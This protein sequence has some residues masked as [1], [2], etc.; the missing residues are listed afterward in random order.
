[1]TVRGMLPSFV[2]IIVNLTD[3]PASPHTH[4]LLRWYEVT[5]YADDLCSSCSLI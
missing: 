1:M 5:L 4:I 2:G 3:C